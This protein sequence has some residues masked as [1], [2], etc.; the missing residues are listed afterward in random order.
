[1]STLGNLLF[2]RHPADMTKFEPPKPLA[3]KLKVNRESFTP[4]Q[5]DMICNVI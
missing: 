2:V 1:M 5:H 3:F 4:L